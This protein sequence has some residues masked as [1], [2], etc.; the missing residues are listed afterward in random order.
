[1]TARR[2][3][4]RKEPAHR[5]GIS[6]KRVGEPRSTRGRRATLASP[7]K[8]RHLLMSGRCPFCERDRL[9]IP[10]IHTFMVHGVDKRELRELA[11]LNWTTS[12][13]PDVTAQRSANMRRMR[14]AGRIKM[15]TSGQSKAPYRY[16]SAGLAKQRATLNSLRS[17][18][19]KAQ[20]KNPIAC[21]WCGQRFIPASHSGKLRLTCSEACYRRFQASRE[22]SNWETLKQEVISKKRKCRRCGRGGRGK[23]VLTAHHIVSKKFGG[24]TVRANLECI[25]LDC[26]SD[27]R[28]ERDRLSRRALMRR[29]SKTKTRGT[30]S[31]R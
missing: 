24:Q 10:A 21:A 4:V 29:A 23:T 25:C 27:Q 3:K 30:K 6:P 22:R 15:P 26:L 7:A 17:A 19:A 16:S 18:R 2:G 1:M 11:G 14:K 8:I 20:A 31:A 12:I 28:R 5:G 9:Q 13:S